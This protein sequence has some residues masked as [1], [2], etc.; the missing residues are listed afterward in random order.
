MI[1]IWRQSNLSHPV[2]TLTATD[3]LDGLD[4]VPGFACPVRDL[5]GI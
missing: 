5:F 1:D 3:T 4:D 2:L